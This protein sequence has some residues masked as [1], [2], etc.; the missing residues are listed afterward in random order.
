MK[1]TWRIDSP[2]LA[3]KTKE[4]EWPLEAETIEEIDDPK[5]PPEREEALLTP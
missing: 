3:L 5:V 2:L 1:E 4:H